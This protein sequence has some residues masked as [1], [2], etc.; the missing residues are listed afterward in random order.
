MSINISP[1][2]A[3]DLAKQAVI[4]FHQG[5][6]I[7]LEPMDEMQHQNEGF[8]DELS[9]NSDIRYWANQLLFF[10]RTVHGI[11]NQALLEQELDET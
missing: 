4:L 3:F 2:V 1:K 10:A 5:T 7:V 6:G 11:F 9:P 8:I